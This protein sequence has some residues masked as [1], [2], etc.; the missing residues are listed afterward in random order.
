MIKVTF[1]IK[2]RLTALLLLIKQTKL[3]FFQMFFLFSPT[4]SPPVFRRTVF[5]VQS[6]TD[7]YK[8]RPG[9]GLATG[10][11]IRRHRLRVYEETVSHSQLPVYSQDSTHP[12]NTAACATCPLSPILECH[13]TS[14][15][16][17]SYLQV[18]LGQSTGRTCFVKSFSAAPPAHPL[19]AGT[20]QSSTGIL[21]P[22]A[23]H[24]T[25][26]R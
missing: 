12:G 6:S 17:T 15:L 23:R 9:S 1:W 8:L 22:S 4:S 3:A 16:L 24:W 13:L 5:M 7:P 10:G 19:Q 11:R 21:G 18:I 14:P 20:Q 2:G 26:W 25:E